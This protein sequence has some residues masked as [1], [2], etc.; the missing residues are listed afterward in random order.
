M[1]ELPVRDQLDGNASAV[2]DAAAWA[3]GDMQERLHIG[4]PVTAVT[5]RSA[6]ASRPHRK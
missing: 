3:R 2:R 6:V 5:N 1:H 4:Q